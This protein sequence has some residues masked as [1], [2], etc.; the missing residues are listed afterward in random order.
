M[1]DNG[2]VD[3]ISTAQVV[4]AV[5]KVCKGYDKSLHSKVKYPETYG[6]CLT[7][8]ARRAI[9]DAVPGMD[10]ALKSA[11]RE[12]RRTPYRMPGRLAEAAYIALQTRCNALGRT[13]QE[14]MTEAVEDWLAKTEKEIAPRAATQRDDK[15][16]VHYQ[17]NREIQKMQSEG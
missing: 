1:K 7:Y 5:K 9:I 10:E 12:N 11:R 4:A 16:N 3:K 6:I 13:M 8:R 17:H 15:T 2:S 14:C